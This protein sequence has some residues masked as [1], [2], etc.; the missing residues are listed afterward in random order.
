[1]Y[2]F[3]ALLNLQLKYCERCGSLWLRPDGAATPYCPP[4]EQF[5]AELPVRPD[6]HQRK[7]VLPAHAPA[8]DAM[9]ALALGASLTG[10]GGCA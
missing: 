4:C 9:L 2:P 3:N 7:P 1:M 6:R 10:F 5:M 8:A